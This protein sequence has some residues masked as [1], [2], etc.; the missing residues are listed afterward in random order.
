M[1][2]LTSRTD[3][4]VRPERKTPLLDALWEWVAR[5]THYSAVRRLRTIAQQQDL[6]A[7]IAVLHWDVTVAVTSTRGGHEKTVVARGTRDAAPVLL[8]GFKGGPGIVVAERAVDGQAG[9]VMTTGDEVTA[10]IT[11]DFTGRLVSLVWVRLHPDH[12]RNGNAFWL[13][14]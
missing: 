12:L 10:M 3:V 5:P 11:V 8:H 2:T 6:A 9:L 13:A 14:D 1:N 7:L 4:R